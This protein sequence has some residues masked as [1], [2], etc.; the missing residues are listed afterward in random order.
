MAVVGTDAYILR[1]VDQMTAP[2]RAI[3]AQVEKLTAGMDKLTKL[4]TLAFAGGAVLG[5]V[6]LLGGALSAVVSVLEAGVSAAG[7]FGSAI[8]KATMFRQRN[9]P[10]LDVLLGA[11]KGE[12]AFQSALRIGRL[13]SASELDVV[14]QVKELAGAGYAGAD[15]DRVNAALLDVHGFG[16]NEA[17][18]SLRYY[19]TKFK[20]G[21]SVE[22]DDLRMAAATAG[23]KERDLLTSALGMAGVKT[24]GLND[25]QLGK[26]VE[27]A[28]RAGKLT[29][30]TVSEA[31]MQAIRMK[32][33]QGGKLGDFAV[34][35]GQ[36]S[37][38]SLLS[39]LEDAPQ[40]FLAQ[41]KL[42]ELPGVRSL[43]SFIQ[44]ILVFFDHG[45]EQGK[46]L[47]RVVE[48]ITN[49]LFGGLDMITG[50]DLARWFQGAVKVAEKLVEVIKS[51]WA[52]IDKM[53]HGD[54]NEALRAGEELIKQVGRLIGAGIWEGIKAGLPGFG[55][56]TTDLHAEARGA[57]L[58]GE[59]AY[60]QA[61][62]V[63]AAKGAPA[64]GELTEKKFVG[65]PR[66]GAPSTN[67]R[68][69][70][71]TINGALSPE[72]ARESADRLIEAIRNSNGRTTNTAGGG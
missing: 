69:E 35:I 14:T 19:V 41:M 52:W 24:S 44:R 7:R 50:D 1:M 6:K 56:S 2:L 5:G 17:M 58:R 53:A 65:T 30:E 3:T 57:E 27:S 21:L 59:D 64:P 54:L 55:G 42:E 71:L 25:A 68:V 46:Q 23:I 8:V 40:S 15:L 72:A 9:I 49:A 60:A 22:R 61:L 39:N 26:Q 48:Q 38:A 36:G 18:N 34:K 47:A 31:L 11:G 70:S 37:M 51:A 4:G 32:L 43:M 29:G 13:T 12:G 16:G 66:F 67:V 28:K 20:G 10:A 45:T 62:R 63:A 33:D